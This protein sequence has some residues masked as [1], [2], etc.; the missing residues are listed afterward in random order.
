[1]GGWRTLARLERAGLLLRH[2][3]GGLRHA[4]YRLPEVAR[5][6]AALREVRRAHRPNLDSLSAR[7]EMTGP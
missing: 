6:V 5:V 3:P 4:R 7:A 2:Y 1:V